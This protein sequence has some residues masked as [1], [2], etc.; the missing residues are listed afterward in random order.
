M[1][2]DTR[3]HRIRLWSRILSLALLAVAGVVPVVTVLVVGAMSQDQLAMGAHIPPARITQVSLGARAAIIGLAALPSLIFS[4]ALLS[5][6]P[7]LAELRRDAFF[8]E[9][10]FRALKCFSGALLLATIVRI[11]VMPL[12]GLILSIGE[13]EGSMSITVGFDAIL[14]VVLAGGT[15]LLAWLIAEASAVA[16][17]NQQFV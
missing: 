7:A 6:R 15:W 10:V 3:R 16:A 11:A 13:A 17:E 14:S 2:H 12:T 4:Y 9:T 1:D 8:S 5:L